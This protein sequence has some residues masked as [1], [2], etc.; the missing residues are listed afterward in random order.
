MRAPHSQRLIPT[1]LQAGIGFITNFFDTLG[2]GS[3]APTTSFFRFWKLVPDRV[4]PGTLN[5]GHTLPRVLQAFIYISIVE[6][7]LKTLTLMISAPVI[8]SWLGAGIVAGW[9]R[10]K[11]QIGMGV[12]LLSAARI[13]G[14]RL[15]EPQ[16]KPR[17][18]RRSVRPS[19]CGP[20]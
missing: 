5:V 9:T 13:G 11:V 6:V 8:G 16:P 17:R 2:I 15:S 12:S 1:L 4:I 18:F 3:F 19:S 7:D 14:F 10:R 20:R